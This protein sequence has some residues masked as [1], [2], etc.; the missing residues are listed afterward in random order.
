M[1]NCDKLVV[2]CGESFGIFR[3]W[4]FILLFG[5][6]VRERVVMGEMV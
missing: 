6:M 4:E 1:L 2:F 3:S 5:V